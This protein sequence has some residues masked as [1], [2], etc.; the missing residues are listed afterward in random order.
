MLSPCLVICNANIFPCYPRMCSV[1]VYLYLA[2]IY[3]QAFDI[4]FHLNS[5]VLMYR[6]L[7]CE[8]D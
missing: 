5:F 2:W 3:I 4:T 6:R 1:V 7:T 8:Q